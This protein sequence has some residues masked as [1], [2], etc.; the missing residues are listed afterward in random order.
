MTEGTHDPAILTRNTAERYSKR[1]SQ[2]L[3]KALWHVTADTRY[4]LG[5]ILG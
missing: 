3:H 5:W 2:L 4:A 1:N